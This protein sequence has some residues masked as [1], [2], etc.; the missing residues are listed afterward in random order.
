MR[1]QRTILPVLLV[2][3]LAPPALAHHIGGTVRCDRDHDGVIDV[4]GDTPVSG[5]TVRISSLDVEPGLV[6]TDTTDANGAYE[7]GLPARTDRYRVELVGLPAGFSV[8]VPGGGAFTV[9]IITGGPLDHKDDV[10][11]LLEGCAPT[12]TT[13]TSTSTTTTTTTPP[14]VCVCPAVPFLVAGDAKINNDAAVSGSVGAN[15]LGGRV[16][17]GKDVIV[18]DGTRLIG[19]T[20]QIGNSSSVDDVLTNHLLRGQSVIIR[21]SIGVPS[22]PIVTPFCTI[23]PIACGGMDITV[24]PNA[25]LG[26][27][28]PGTYGRARILNGASLILAPGTFTF[29]DI[30]MGRN[31][32]L[33]TADF[34]TVNVAGTV[35]IGTASRVGPAVGDTPVPINVAGKKIRVSQSAVA[36]VAFVAPFSRI[37]FGR[38][39]N[40]RGC[41]CTDRAKSDK[42]ITL[43]CVP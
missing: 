43:E 17:L 5:I 18:A 26:P 29:C 3:A 25:T 22:L 39:A 38:D 36:N 15:N 9:Q 40:L 4:P 31:A 14:I 28:A 6:F 30:K 13:T 21:G 11:F 37:T 34:A 19:D 16:R 35:T 27:L 24:A 42:H 23:P 10:D 12:T 33:T 32:S 2:L 8:V 1:L 41:F 20:V 7:V